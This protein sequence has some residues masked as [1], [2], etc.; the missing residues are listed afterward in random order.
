MK[1]VTNICRFLTGVV[2]IISG[3]IKA[4]DPLGFSYKLKEYFEVFGYP[5]FGPLA[6]YIAI[7]ICVFEIALGVAVL[8]GIAME[9]TSWLLLLMIVFFTF[10]T[11]YSAYFNKVTDC[12]C[13]GDALHLTP[14]QSFSK[15]IVLLV[16]IL[17]I[18]SQR[19]KIV[20]MF[21]MR[22]GRSIVIVA[23]L[24]SLVFSVWC[25]RHLPVVDFR[26][27]KVGT[28]ISAA[29]T[30]P[31]NAKKSIYQT[32]LYYEKDGVVKEFTDKNYPWQDSTWVYKDTK[33]ILLQKGDEAPIHDFHIEDADHNDLTEEKLSYE[34]YN[35]ILVA[36]DLKNSD[37]KVQEKVN[38]F[39]VECQKQNIPFIGLTS[40]SA[41]ETDLFRHEVQAMYDYYFCDGT[42]L[43]TFIRSNPGLVL[44]KGG[45][46]IRMWHHNDFPQFDELS[47][48]YGMTK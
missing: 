11:F 26:P 10:L 47:K 32:L 30:L 45:T 9:L 36:Y 48:Q 29:M 18:F 22:A 35:F 33:N 39:V 15:D 5:S 16:F 7:F 31:P 4:N 3:L 1:F 23:T 2:F 13:F 25:Y 12:G 44:L 21:G 34:G 19:K 24:S 40:T 43:Q 42:A 6:L 14:W 20:G 27:Y 37:R 38:Q 46:V 28:N 41:E 17:I 8:F